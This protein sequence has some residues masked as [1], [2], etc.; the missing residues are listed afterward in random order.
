[1]VLGGYATDG[2]WDPAWHPRH[3][4]AYLPPRLRRRVARLR[5]I[6]KQRC[7]GPARTMDSC[8]DGDATPLQYLHAYGDGASLHGAAAR[9]PII[10]SATSSLERYYTCMVLYLNGIIVWAGVSNTVLVGS[11]GCGLT[12]GRTDDGGGR[13]WEA[14]LRQRTHDR[15]HVWQ[16]SRR[17]ARVHTGATLTHTTHT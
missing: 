15:K 7:K 13:Y 12:D 11:V 3:N 5:M 17:L 1:V 9:E 6:E 4:A 16:C 8:N 2:R 14:H 10:Y